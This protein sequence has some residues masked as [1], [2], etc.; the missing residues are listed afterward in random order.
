MLL[1]RIYEPS[2][3]KINWDSL[4]VI[5]L[6]LKFNFKK[7]DYIGVW[8]VTQSKA[9]LTQCYIKLKELTT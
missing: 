4:Y 7:S 1:T 5:T 9:N 8:I 6:Q 3:E 2:K